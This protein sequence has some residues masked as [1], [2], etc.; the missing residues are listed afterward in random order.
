MG[1]MTAQGVCEHVC[2]ASKLFG[3]VQGVKDW[4]VSEFLPD[5]HVTISISVAMNFY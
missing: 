5:M 4:G 1:L 3:K 2:G